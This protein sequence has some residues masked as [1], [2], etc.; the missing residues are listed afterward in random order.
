MSYM[1]GDVNAD[2]GE[3]VFLP[4]DDDGVLQHIAN[5]VH[6]VIADLIGFTTNIW[7]D[8]TIVFP[9]ATPPTS[10]AQLDLSSILGGN[11]CFAFLKVKKTSGWGLAQ[12][13][14]FRR[15]GD[16]GDYVVNPGNLLRAAGIVTFQNTNEIQ[17]TCCPT[18]ENGIIEWRAI[19]SNSDVEVSVI[20]F[21]PNLT[22]SGPEMIS[23]Y[24]TGSVS[25]DVDHIECVI[26]GDF[27]VDV[28]TVDL[29]VTDPVGKTSTA[30]SGGAV[31]AG[32]TG[33][34]TDLTSMVIV[35]LTGWPSG[36]MEKGK[37]YS[38]TADADN[39]LGLSM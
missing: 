19:S 35:N 38:F 12:H 10:Y 16:S 21:S 14:G 8:E 34:V 30:V 33:T 1:C 13:V 25:E 24:P 18:D 7:G 3:Y 29:V 6:N 15:N 11:E 17:Y 20:G 5:G 39:V 23:T 31:Q 22:P 4:T 37:I 27:P 2:R 32:W 28:S 36:Y 9:D 26:G